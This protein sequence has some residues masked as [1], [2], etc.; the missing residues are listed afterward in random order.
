MKSTTK[1]ERWVARLGCLKPYI[2]LVGDKNPWRA[3]IYENPAK[4]ILLGNL[5][6]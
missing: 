5:Y 6:H 3:L 1:A 2:V 4:A